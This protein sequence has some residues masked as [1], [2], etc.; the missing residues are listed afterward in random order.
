MWNTAAATLTALVDG[1]DGAH[2]TA[3][4]VG[5]DVDGGGG[6]ALRLRGIRRAAAVL[7]CLRVAVCSSPTKIAVG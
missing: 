5:S 3:V 6:G 4:P 7:P 1:D 2:C